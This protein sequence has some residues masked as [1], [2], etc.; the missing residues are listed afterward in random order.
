MARIAFAPQAVD[1]LRDV[2]ADLAERAGLLIAGNY[3]EQLRSSFERLVAHPR[4]GGPRPRFGRIVRI[5]VG[6][7]YLVIYRVQRNDVIIQ[8][9]V[10]G[11]RKI[12]R[13][14]VTER[15]DPS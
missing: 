7:P 11:H 9:V 10:H 14:T 6:R 8:R 13:R 1:D 4:S 12:T 3:T 5:V 2:R 15:T